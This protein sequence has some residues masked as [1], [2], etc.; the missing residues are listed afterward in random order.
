ML[1]DMIKISPKMIQEGSGHTLPTS[2]KVVIKGAEQSTRNRRL[3]S[4]PSKNEV[5]INRLQ[6]KNCCIGVEGF[7]QCLRSHPGVIR[8]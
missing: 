5:E 4:T 1:T 8:G 7:K 3:K 2:R 6:K